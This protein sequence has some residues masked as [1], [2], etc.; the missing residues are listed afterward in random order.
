MILE[1]DKYYL[2]SKYGTTITVEKFYKGSDSPQEFLHKYVKD[3]NNKLLSFDSEIEA[4]E[5]NFLI[6]SFVTYFQ[7]YEE[8]FCIKT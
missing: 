1:K 2:Y 4:I 7:T 6:N 8:I 3:K 5:L